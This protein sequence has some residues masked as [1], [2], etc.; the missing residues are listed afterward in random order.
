MPM[1]VD[2]GVAAHLVHALADADHRRQVEDHVGVA[3]QRRERVGVTDVAA[4]QSMRRIEI[5]R[6]RSGLAV[7][8]RFEVVEERDV[9]PARGQGIG[10]VRADEAG[11]AGDQD[12]F[13]HRS[14]VYRLFNPKKRREYHSDGADCHD[15]HSRSDTYRSCTATAGRM[16]SA[17]MDFLS[18]LN[19]SSAAPPPCPLATTAAI[20]GTTDRP[21][22]P[23]AT[24][25]G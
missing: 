18:S 16:V 17:A 10:Q 24:A 21:R 2:V 9:V 14:A 13:G 4:D 23:R 22:I 6:S 1:R 25:C 12:A 8:L 5:G 3:Q 11:A 15:R 20:S 7:D 19:E